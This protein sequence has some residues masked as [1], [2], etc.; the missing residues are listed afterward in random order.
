MF[1]RYVIIMY[2][3]QNKSN[4]YYFMLLLKFIKHKIIHYIFYLV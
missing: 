4:F 1:I 3:L 2:I